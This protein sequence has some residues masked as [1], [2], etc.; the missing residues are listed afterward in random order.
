M[1]REI[2]FLSRIYFNLCGFLITTA[3]FN[4]DVFN[5]A[6]GIEVTVRELAETILFQLNFSGKLNFTGELRPGDPVNWRADVISKIKAAGYSGGTDI[7]QGIKNY[8]EWLREEE[9]L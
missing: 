6:N 8:I 7:K 3:L 4:G 1:S 5:I 9:L 2:L